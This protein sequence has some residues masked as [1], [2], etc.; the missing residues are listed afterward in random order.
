[1]FLP[2]IKVSSSLPKA[3]CQKPFSIKSKRKEQKES[4]GFFLG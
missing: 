4:K 2:W 3:N 1:M